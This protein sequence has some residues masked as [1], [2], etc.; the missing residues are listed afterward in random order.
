MPTHSFELVEAAAAQQAV[1]AGEIE[2][3]H[4]PQAL[5]P[6][7]AGQHLVTVALGGFRSEALLA[8][9][10]LPPPAGLTD[11]QWRWCLDFVRQG[12]PSLAAYPDFAAPA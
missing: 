1:R 3:R 9:V 12:S 4:G 11:D 6:G 10:R 8:E 2:Q 7:R 5:P